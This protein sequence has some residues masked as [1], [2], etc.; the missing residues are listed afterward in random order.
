MRRNLPT[1]NCYENIINDSF[2]MVQ[3]L[4]KERAFVM[5]GHQMG[6]NDQKIAKDFQAII[7]LIYYC[8]VF[9][10]FK[11]NMQT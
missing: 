8:N 4:P 6:R 3:L 2:E 7:L 9:I 1:S 10:F 11:Y 5:R